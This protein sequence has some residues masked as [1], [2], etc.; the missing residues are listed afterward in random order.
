MRPS[1]HATPTR[2][3]GRWAGS[4]L[5]SSTS[6]DAASTTAPHAGRVVEGT[7]ELTFDGRVE[8]VAAGDGFVIPGGFEGHKAKALPPRTVLFI[9]EDSQPSYL[10]RPA[11]GETPEFAA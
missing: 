8:H 6:F 3:I 10:W 2:P 4:S 9:V 7:L 1:T 11:A 5:P